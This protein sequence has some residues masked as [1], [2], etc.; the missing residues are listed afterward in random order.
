MRRYSVIWVTDACMSCTC[1]FRLLSVERLRVGCLSRALLCFS[2]DEGAVCESGWAVVWAARVYIAGAGAV[3][4][5]IAME[6]VY[7]KCLVV[8]G[9]TFG[10]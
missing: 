4:D 10:T 1:S 9:G 5:K 7:S 8:I 3:I 2:D 6:V